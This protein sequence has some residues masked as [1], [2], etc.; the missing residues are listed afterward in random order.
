[1]AHDAAGRERVIWAAPDGPAVTA[2]VQVG[3]VVVS[4]RPDGSGASV[5]LVRSGGRT[6]AL[7]PDLMAPTVPDLIDTGLGLWLLLLGAL[8]LARAS[9]RGAGRAFW[10]TCVTAGLALGMAAAATHGLRPALAAQ[11]A[12]LRL[13]GPAFLETP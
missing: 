5:L 11:F 6:L 3:D 10:A 13:F 12:T 7:G 9:D 2:G 8:V 4:R 1:V